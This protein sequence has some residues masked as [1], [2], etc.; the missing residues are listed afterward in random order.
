LALVARQRSRPAR[1]HRQRGAGRSSHGGGGRAPDAVPRPPDPAH[2]PRDAL[3]EMPDF[4]RAVRACRVSRHVIRLVLWR[5]VMRR[6]FRAF[7][8]IPLWLLFLPAASTSASD[9]NA[10]KL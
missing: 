6:A 8:P 10:L 4:A 9:A 3:P 7:R 1:S 2:R 5:T